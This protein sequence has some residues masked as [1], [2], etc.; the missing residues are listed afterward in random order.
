MHL[1]DARAPPPIIQF[2][3]SLCMRRATDGDFYTVDTYPVSVVGSCA[4]VKQR[5]S[6]SA[7]IADISSA[8]PQGGLQ[9]AAGRMAWDMHSLKNTAAAARKE[10]RKEARKQGS[11]EAK[12]GKKEDRIVL[13]S[14]SSCSIIFRLFSRSST[15]NTIFFSFFFFFFFFCFGCGRFRFTQ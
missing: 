12:E 14:R 8:L 5:A 7:V 11:K 4:S 15:Y 6:E 2:Y 13:P 3:D 10:G 9:P 1:V